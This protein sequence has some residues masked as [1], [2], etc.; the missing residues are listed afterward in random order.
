MNRILTNAKLKSEIVKEVIGLDEYEIAVGIYTY[1][2]DEIGD[3]RIEVII[4]ED[5]V[6]EVTDYEAQTEEYKVNSNLKKEAEKI[7]KFLQ[8]NN[9]T[10]NSQIVESTSY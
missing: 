3:Q 4:N 6:I 7:V 1:E 2:S 5:V 10:V 8:Q 9:I